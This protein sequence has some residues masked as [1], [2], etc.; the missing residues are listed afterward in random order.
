M[1]RQMKLQAP[2]LVVPFRQFLWLVVCR[3]RSLSSL[4]VAV[5]VAVAVVVVLCV[6]AVWC[7][8]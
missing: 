3:C 5:A 2:L 4:C 7:V 6:C 1:L 8:P